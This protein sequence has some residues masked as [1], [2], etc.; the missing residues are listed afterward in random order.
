MQIKIRSEANLSPYECSQTV[1]NLSNGWG[2][3]LL[4]RPRVAISPPG[5]GSNSTNHGRF[6]GYQGLSFRVGYLIN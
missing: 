5:G 2:L 4:K 6:F 3:S 1:E